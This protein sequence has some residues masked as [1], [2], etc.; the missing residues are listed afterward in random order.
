MKISTV[1]TYSLLACHVY[2]TPITFKRDILHGPIARSSRS[3][4]QNRSEEIHHGNRASYSSIWSGAVIDS[5]PEGEAFNSVSASFVIPKPSIPEGSPPNNYYTVAAWV[6]IDGDTA[7]KAILQTGVDLT[8]EG[9]QVYYEPWYEWWPDHSYTFSEN[10]AISPGDVIKATVSATSST[11]GFATIENV[12]T[13][14][15]VTKYLTSTY[16]LAQQNAEWIVENYMMG[17][18]ASA[19]HTPLANWSSIVFTDTKASTRKSWLDASN[20]T[21][22]NMAQN[23]TVITEVTIDGSSVIDTYI[24]TGK[25]PNL[26]ADDTG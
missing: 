14:K 11:S 5:P 8:I 23:K 3:F 13:G 12:S 21:A 9:G 16:A 18:G 4:Q 17:L 26:K 7:S 25:T 22:I 2:A 10:L 20:A 6:G 15:L 24:F 1:V 19:H